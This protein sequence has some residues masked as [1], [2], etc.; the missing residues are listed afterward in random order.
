MPVGLQRGTKRAATRDRILATAERLFAEYGYDG[1]SMRQ[2][3]AEADAQIALIAYH[4]GTKEKLYRAVFEHRITPLSA[5][6]RE[7]LARARA[8]ASSACLLLTRASKA[9]SCIPNRGRQFPFCC[10]ILF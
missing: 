1:V 9:A 2:I 7:A 4:F 6:R 5:R 3:G 10:D 8:A